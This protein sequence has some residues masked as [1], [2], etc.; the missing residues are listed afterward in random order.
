MFYFGDDFGTFTS[1]ELDEPFRIVLTFLPRSGVVPLPAPDRGGAAGEEQA[2]GA[3]QAQPPGPGPGAVPP[4]FPGP[5]EP[6]ADDGRFRVVLDPGHGGAE[7]GAIGRSGL[8]EKDLV[9]DIARRLR[10]RLVAGG[11]AVDL[12]RDGDETID[13]TERAAIA[14]GKGADLFVSIHANSSVRASARGAET[15]FLSYGSGATDDQAMAL[16][17]AENAPSGEGGA[18][19]G[20][21]LVLWEMAQADHLSRSSEA[22][23]LIQADLNA[24]A[25]L[26]DR[27]VKQAPFRVLVGAAMPAVLVE[28]GFLTNADE[29]RSL[30]G[31]DYRERIAV[32]LAGAIGRFRDRVARA[33]AGAVQAP[34]T[35]APR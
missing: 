7:E 1:S 11:I 33:D 26:A 35:G 27:G 12:T 18:G 19:G 6:P 13:L 2:P 23:E 10:A 28:V 21:D 17:R 31:S 16:A 14:N 34:A 15:Y 8:K 20:I 3:P 29:E 24:L 25:G 22:A 30:A 5:A 4:G 9:L 32:A